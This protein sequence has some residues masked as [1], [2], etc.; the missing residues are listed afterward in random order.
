MD[1]QGHHADRL[2][3]A[4]REIG[5]EIPEP[6]APRSV[7]DAIASMECTLPASWASEVR[8]ARSVTWG[9]LGL[10][11]LAASLTVAASVLYVERERMR[12][13]LEQ[14]RA[15][16]RAGFVT[17]LASVDAAPL[18]VA[19]FDVEGC[20]IAGQM[21]PWFREKSMAYAGQPVIFVDFDMSS[22]CSAS[23]K[24]LAHELGVDCVF[25]CDETP[26]ESGTVMLV[27]RRSREVI[28]TCRGADDLGK[29]EAALSN[30]MM[31]CSAP[32]QSPTP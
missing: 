21:K 14:A 13:D 8:V 2:H 17:Q 15:D 7:R 22:G 20:P 26:V 6:R 16:L 24:Q 32:K 3:D 18:M 9:M 1:E 28:E 30:A 11:A 5:A 10:G 4:L 27:D 19:A 23:S 25:E 29:V 31:T 12:H